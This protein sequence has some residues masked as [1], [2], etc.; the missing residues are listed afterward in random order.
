MAN[1]PV[2]PDPVSAR[3]M[4]SLPCEKQRGWVEVAVGRYRIHLARAKEDSESCPD[5]VPTEVRVVQA[6]H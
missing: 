1:A 3:P 4:T 5:R 2:L 6:V